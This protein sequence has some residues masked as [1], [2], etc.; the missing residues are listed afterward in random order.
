MNVFSLKAALIFAT[1]ATIALSAAP[2]VTVTVSTSDPGTGNWGSEH[3]IVLWIE[4]AAGAFIKTFGRWGYDYGA[5]DLPVWNS[6]KTVSTVDGTTGATPTTYG[7]VSATWNLTGTN[8]SRVPNGTYHY[9]IELSN[10]HNHPYYVRG[11]IAIDGTSKTATGTDSSV[12]SASTFLKNVTAAYVDNGSSIRNP[13]LAQK[14]GGLRGFITPP[15]FRSGIMTMRLVAP[16]GRMLWQNTYSTSAGNSIAV[17]SRDI[18]I[19]EGCNGVGVLI[20]D[21]GTQKISRPFLFM[22]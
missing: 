4:N 11:T 15:S 22:K 19:P 8:G 21:Y 2:G 3:D 1:T 14:A 18:R 12:N 13:P 17:P 16:D 6:R 7:T 10:N 9:C 5:S 20:A